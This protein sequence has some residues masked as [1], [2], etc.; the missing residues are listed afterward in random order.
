MKLSISTFAAIVAISRPVY[1][2][3]PQSNF[4]VKSPATTIAA[5]TALWSTM[6]DSG[7]PPATSV[8]EVEDGIL[9]TKL[10]SDVGFD[11]VPLASALAAGDLAQAD[12][13]RIQCSHFSPVKKKLFTIQA[14]S[15]KIFL[16]GHPIIHW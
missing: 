2:F 4:A 11:Y 12:Q 3:A 6:A 13:V 14:Y 16:N 9:P 1:G 10:P 8:G 5:S 15:Y 7:V